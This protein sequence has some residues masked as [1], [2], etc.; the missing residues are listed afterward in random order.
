MELPE[1]TEEDLYEQ[2]FNKVIEEDIY[3]D[4]GNVEIEGDAGLTPESTFYFLEN[5]VE[6]ILVGDNPQR[7]LKYKEEKILEL[8]EMIESG[9]EEA[10]KEVLE[11]VKKYNNI[12]KK[13]VSP[14]IEKR[15]RES[16]KATKQVLES[17]NLEDDKWDDVKKI[18]DE[19]LKNEDKIALAAKIS[20]K[21]A[22]L[23]ETLS[24]LDPLQYSNV[25]KTDDDSPKW[26]RDLDDRLTS[27][28]REEAEEFFKIMTQCIE[29]SGRECRC[30]DI[31][32]PAFADKCAIIAPLEAL[33][34]S[35]DE[36]ACDKVDAETE[37]I[38]DLLP[39][40]LLDILD[41]VIEGFDDE[42][43]ESHGPPREC[44]EVGATSREDCMKVMFSIH[45]PPEC[46][47]ALER[48]EIDIK[49]EN[50]ARKQCEE[51]MFNLEGDNECK[52]EGIRDH[53]ECERFM[54]KL[55]S[56]Q[57]CI[58]AGLTG[59]GRDD[60]RKCDAI[61]FKLDAPQECLD[62]GIDGSG[63]D[64]WKKC[65][66]INFRLDSPQEC[67]DAGLDGRGR[68]DW[69]KC[70]VI[71]FK[72]EAAPECLD[73]GLD[74]SGRNDWDKCNAIN[75]R[76]DAPQECLDAGL[77]GSGRNDHRECEAIRF[78]LE[79]HLDCLAAGLDG[80]GRRDWDEC[81]KIQFRSDAPQEC[82]DAGLDGSGRNDWQRC[83][84]ITQG[85]NPDYDPEQSKDYGQGREE[86][87]EKQIHTCDDNGYNCRC[88]SYDGSDDY[89]PRKEDYKEEDSRGCETILCQDGFYCENGQCIQF[90]ESYNEPPYEEEEEYIE[91]IV[92]DAGSSG[93]SV[94]EE[95]P[96]QEPLPEQEDGSS[97][98]NDEHEESASSEGPSSDSEE[99][100]Q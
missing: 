57:E 52:E 89:V 61:M 29:T 83:D 64:D 42:D 44:R 79:A 84:E 85:N 73:A 46:Q 9:N 38:E 93:E 23:C 100:T 62:A 48:G 24:A 92:D 59:L 30:N 80:T 11:K 82:I 27:E 6:T 74:G 5:L 21:I 99:V 90:E 19:N 8:K 40:F 49:N 43:F 4:I 91:P 28:Q 51:I 17:F 65:E 68:D 55:E 12:I 18:I 22:E 1:N 60:W 94:P 56:P 58:D 77:D 76:L 3:E 69:R 39:D 37:N 31:S 14:E 66:V 41:R 75:F 70:D 45:A 86:C 71:R 34:D 2:E 15:V 47:E 72:L 53:R 10:A 96:Q 13:E 88:E 54:F 20:S 35:G 81:Q 26:K 78:R 7:A 36:S 97:G 50:Q 98:S 25:C 95:I 16:S 67:L 32:I 33:C 87:N 63:R